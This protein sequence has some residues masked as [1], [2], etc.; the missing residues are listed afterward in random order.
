M[1]WGK[2]FSAAGLCVEAAAD[3]ERA[4]FPN[5][6]AFSLVANG[7]KNPVARWV[8][9]VSQGISDWSVILGEEA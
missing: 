3:C 7:V 2:W 8:I 1:D 5:F 4:R 6:D 9:P